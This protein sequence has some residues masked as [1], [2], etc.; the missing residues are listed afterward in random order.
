MKVLKILDREYI[1]IID[2]SQNHVISL[3]GQYEMNEAILLSS[4]GH[5]NLLAKIT[6]K[7]EFKSIEEVFNVL[8]LDL[9]GDFSSHK[10]ALTFY[11]SIIHGEKYYVYRVKYDSDTYHELLDDKLTEMIDMNSI[12]KNNIGHSVC[13]VLEVKL[14]NGADA[15]LKVQFMSGRNNLKDEYERLTWLKAHGIN[16]PSVYYFNR[17][18]GVEYLLMEKI[19]GLPAFKYSGLC[20]KL[21]KELR[22]IHDLYEY[23]PSFTNNS[24]DALLKQ[25]LIKIDSILPQI[26][27]L[28]PDFTK[29]SVIQF[30]IE[31]KP[32][33][34]VLVHGDYSLPN[35]LVDSNEN[36]GFIDLGD[37]SIS[38]KYFDFFYFVKSL[39]RNKKIDELSDFMSGYGIE[40]FDPII[41]K[42]MEIMDIIIY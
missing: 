34:D 26:F 22:K 24:T 35:I 10:D 19:L 9:F 2:G 11:S 5:D 31:N 40:E 17:I 3:D 32:E 29:E 4:D 23:N 8:P 20:Y 12:I 37:V 36:I 25:V 33:N 7:T 39:K 13:E 16:S 30:M 15:I 42:W 1:N 28:Y 27:E 14:K 18:N 38:S 41:M 6:A 21:G